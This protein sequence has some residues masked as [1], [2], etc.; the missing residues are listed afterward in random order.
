MMTIESTFH[1]TTCLFYKDEGINAHWVDLLRNAF[2]VTAD[3]LL[4]IF[5]ANL[6]TG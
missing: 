4:C 3:I 6:I 5:F 2:L 1:Q